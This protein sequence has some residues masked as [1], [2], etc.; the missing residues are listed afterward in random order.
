M[1]DKGLLKVFAMDDAIVIAIVS[2]FFNK[3]IPPI[4]IIPTIT[5]AAAYRIQRIGLLRCRD[6]T[7]AFFS[8]AGIAT[9]KLAK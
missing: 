7:F 8:I 2:L 6:I 1:V 4:A 5:A 9:L 3:N